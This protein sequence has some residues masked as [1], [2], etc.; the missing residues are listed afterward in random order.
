MDFC[1]TKASLQ[2]YGYGKNFKYRK[3]VSFPKLVSIEYPAFKEFD[4]KY[5]EWLPIVVET[6]KTISSKIEKYKRLLS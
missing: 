3:K 4:G 5:F 1:E 2:N 6:K